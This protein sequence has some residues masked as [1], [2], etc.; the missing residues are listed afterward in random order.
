MSQRTR[1]YRLLPAHLPFSERRKFQKPVGPRAHSEAGETVPGHRLGQGGESQ[2][3]G[4]LPSLCGLLDPGQKMP[5]RAPRPES[6]HPG[7]SSAGALQAGLVPS[8]ASVSTFHPMR[9]GLRAS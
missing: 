9:K 4:L 6:A 1:G 2:G 5:W 7:P 8:P 3:Q